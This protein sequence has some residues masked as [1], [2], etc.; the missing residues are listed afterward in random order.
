MLLAA[1]IGMSSSSSQ[2]RFIVPNTKVKD[3]SGSAPAFI[4]GHDLLPCRIPLLL[5][6][7]FPD[8]GPQHPRSEEEH[9]PSFGVPAPNAQT[10]HG[11][12]CLLLAPSCLRRWGA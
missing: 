9:I 8:A 10:V 6:A 5:G 1:P 2:F 11:C 12:V 7:A 4:H 3:P